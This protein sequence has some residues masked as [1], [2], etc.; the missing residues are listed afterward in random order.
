MKDF[1]Y[2]AGNGIV[3]LTPQVL[4]GAVLVALILALATATL[5]QALFKKVSRD[6]PTAMAWMILV[7]NVLSMI[8]AVGYMRRQENQTRLSYVPASFDDFTRDRPRPRGRREWMTHEA[9]PLEALGSP[10]RDER[11]LARELIESADVDHDGRLSPGESTHLI[12]SLKPP[13]A[14]PIPEVTRSGDDDR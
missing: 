8:V 7:A 9:P 12:E 13:L 5:Y 1:L 10:R 3:D 2:A 14:S 11:A 4:I 6:N